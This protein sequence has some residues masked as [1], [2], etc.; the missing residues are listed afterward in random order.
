MIPLPAYGYLMKRLLLGLLPLLLY[1]WGLFPGSICAGE[2]FL[3]EKE[4]EAI[5]ENQEISE[6]VKLY[7]QFAET[8][9]KSAEDRLNGLETVEGDPFELLTP[10]QM[11]DGYY[12]IIRSVMLNMDDAY[13]N[14]NPRMR[15]KLR[16]ALKTLKTETAKSSKQLEILKTI[17]EEKRNEELWNLVNKAIDVTNGAREGAE[18]GLSQYSEPDAKKSKAR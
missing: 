12:R 4:I 15:P 1:F 18:F 9:L 17:A 8:R 2:D 6:R 7:L 16:Q 3:T 14:P 11:L 13:R 5:Q 10:E